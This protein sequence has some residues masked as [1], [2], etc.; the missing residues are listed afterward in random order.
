V[1]VGHAVYKAWLAAAINAWMNHFW[2]L[3]QQLAASETGSGEGASPDP[4]RAIYAELA[5]FL[6]LAMPAALVH[7][8]ASWIRNVW[9]FTWRRELM[10]AYVKRW[11][12]QLT[13]LEGASQRIQEDSQRFASGLQGCF[14][15]ILQ[16]VMTTCVFLPILYATDPHLAAAAA[17]IAAG[18][19]GV[20]AL[21]GHP[22]IRLEVN[23]QV[24][25]AEL[26]RRLVLLECA[27][28]DTFGEG[29]LWQHFRDVF[30]D[31]TT[32]YFRLYSA[33]AVLFCWLALHEQVSVIVPYALIAPR[34]FDEQPLRRISMGTLMS[35]AH[36][37]SQVFSSLSVIS[38]QFLSLQEWRSAVFRLRQFE[39]DQRNGS[40]Y[41]VQRDVEMMQAPGPPGHPRPPAH[42]RQPTPPPLTR[43]EP[44]EE[45]PPPWQ[46]APPSIIEATMMVEENLSVADRPL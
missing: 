1:F 7:P 9:V 39:S 32:N 38:D 46:V 42:P 35:S 21:V 27:L 19:L 40:T 28:P 13:A 12:T 10:V 29:G 34:L 43:A 2:T 6:W 20:S 8:V 36:A 25:E 26:R 33:I 14:A 4:V 3:V 18:A 5:A 17:G 15:T 24:V 16:S 30:R 44:V 37:F 45:A 41:S 11:N 31:L 22:L 23:N